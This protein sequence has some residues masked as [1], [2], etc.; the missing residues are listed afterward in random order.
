MACQASASIPA[1]L[2]PVVVTG[3]KLGVAIAQPIVTL[4]D[5]G[6]VDNIPVE[7]ATDPSRTLIRGYDLA[8]EGQDLTTLVFVFDESGDEV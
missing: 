7:Q 2:L 1:I 8:K 4:V 5:G 3:K 6:L